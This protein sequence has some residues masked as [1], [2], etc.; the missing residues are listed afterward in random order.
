M[1]T[2][3]ERN[4]IISSG[5]E[6]EEFFSIK[7]ENAG[8]IFDIL[9]NKLYSDKIL[10]VVREYSCNAWDAHVEAGIPD[11][12]I[13]ITLPTY[14]YPTLKFRDFGYGLSPKEI[15]EVYASYGESTKRNTNSQVGMLGLGSKSAF[16][17]SSNFE[18]VS[19]YK[20]TKY[21]YVAYI[22]ET[23][24]G[25]ISKMGETF[26][27]EECGIEVSIPIKNTDIYKVIAACVNFFKFFEPTPVFH[28]DGSETI[29]AAATAIKNAPV[30]LEGKKWK[31]TKDD[32]YTTPVCIMGNV[33]YPIANPFGSQDDKKYSELLQSNSG[34]VLYADIGDVMV[35]ASREQLEYGTKTIKFLKDSVDTIIFEGKEAFSKKIKDAIA[36]KKN[37]W[38]VKVLLNE[39]S[40]DSKLSY[41]VPDEVKQ[42]K[43]KS[44]S[45]IPQTV[46]DGLK[47]DNLTLQYVDMTTGKYNYKNPAKAKIGVTPSSIAPTS[48][49]VFLLVRNVDKKTVLGRIRKIACSKYSNLYYHSNQME[50][51]YVVRGKTEADIEAF[52]NHPEFSGA[53]TLE[54]KDYEPL[55]VEAKTIKVY[56]KAKFKVFKWSGTNTT[57]GGTGNS[58]AWDEC[59]VDLKEGE[60][61]YIPIKNYLPTQQAGLPG[62]YINSSKKFKEFFTFLESSGI[63][64][65]EPV[66][67]IRETI[68]KDLGD[69]WIPLRTYI[70]ALIKEKLN[71]KKYSKEYGAKVSYSKEQM[72]TPFAIYNR[73]AS[74]KN[75]PTSKLP[76]S[77]FKNFIH[78]LKSI[79]D[80]TA[81]YAEDEENKFMELCKLFGVEVPIYQPT[82]SLTSI[83][84]KIKA[85]YPCI[86]SIM[87]QL[88]RLYYN[89]V[90]QT[91][92][93]ELIRYINLIEKAKQ[94]GL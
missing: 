45:V 70:K 76:N 73:L 55:E 2:L 57:Y 51:I 25:K 13:E 1:K 16:C 92:L 50:P 69:S 3:E 32:K 34:I 39:T 75:D 83:L 82:I 14:L 40:F 65:D 5:V 46:I 15:F 53:P 78:F 89:Q 61:L 79:Q 29:L 68:L 35:S 24:V 62:Y 86:D 77:K 17:Y 22:D 33:T 85:R 26:S 54:L 27:E 60:G 80:F 36:T 81:S 18:I 9:R 31:I 64:I 4:T 12:P 71:T 6:Q 91:N 90:E 38:D 48:K 72:N 59:E 43:D 44:A 19:I 42:A 7:A 56:E 8:H 84:N 30:I 49:A 87:V 21:N 52:L 74:D 88:Y 41:L 47:N 10:S 28:G 93:N 23:N 58:V 37:K 67:G 63:L 11:K 94:N 66:Y 20:G